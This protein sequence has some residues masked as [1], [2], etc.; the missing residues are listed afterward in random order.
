MAAR[1]W[2]AA[3]TSFASATRNESTIRRAWLI[4]VV[5][6]MLAAA[7]GMTHCAQSAKRCGKHDFRFDRRGVEIS[8]CSAD[9]RMAVTSPVS[10][11][12]RV[13]AIRWVQWLGQLLALAGARVN[14]SGTH[15]CTQVSD[16][17]AWLNGTDAD[18]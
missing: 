4:L 16:P 7:G 15:T 3:A 10:A 1:C 2:H 14:P 13:G 17:R 18:A 5:A 6:D 8:R 9:A 12:L 11:G